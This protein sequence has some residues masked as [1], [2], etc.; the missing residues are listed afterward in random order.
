MDSSWIVR[1]H[2]PQPGV[3]GFNFL[4]IIKYFLESLWRNKQPLDDFFFHT[5][6]PDLKEI[7][8]VMNRLEQVS[9]VFQARRGEMGWACR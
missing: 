1:G 3:I 7:I 2:S 6:Y 5:Y 4:I 9:S 8:S